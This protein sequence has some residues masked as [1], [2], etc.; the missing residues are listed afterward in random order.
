MGRRFNGLFSDHHLRGICRQFV[1][2]A[3]RTKTASAEWRWSEYTDSPTVCDCGAHSFYAERLSRYHRRTTDGRENSGPRMDWGTARSA[4]PKG[5]DIRSGAPLFSRVA[6]RRGLAGAHEWT[7]RPERTA[8]DGAF[9]D[10]HP[11]PVHAVEAFSPD[12]SLRIPPGHRLIIC[13]PIRCSV[14]AGDGFPVS[15]PLFVESFAHDS[16]LP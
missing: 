6:G 12:R 5:C 3:D 4:T 9:P 2:P 13:L 16:T 10:S 7:V 11:L 1:G 15:T 14:C 8:D